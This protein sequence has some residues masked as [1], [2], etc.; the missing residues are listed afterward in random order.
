MSYSTAHVLTIQVKKCK[1]TLQ[2][3]EGLSSY[4]TVKLGVFVS[5]QRIHRNNISVAH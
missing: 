1:I 2:S 5:T 4:L 3:L